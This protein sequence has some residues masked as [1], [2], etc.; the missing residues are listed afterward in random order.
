[1]CMGIIEAVQPK[2]GVIKKNVQ[3][4]AQIDSKGRAC[5]PLV[6]YSIESALFTVRERCV[7]YQLAKLEKGKENSI[8]TKRGAYIFGY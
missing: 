3:N 8:Q 5:R 6:A 1:M 4:L 7:T 2:P